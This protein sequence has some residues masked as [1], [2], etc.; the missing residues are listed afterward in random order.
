MDNKQLTK[1][2]SYFIM[3]DGG[4]YTR[5]GKTDSAYFVMNMKAE[6]KDYIDWVDSVLK[7]FVGTRQT[8]RKDYNTDGCNRQP[9]IRLE[10][11]THPKLATLRHRI[12]TEKYKGIDPHALKMLDWEALAILYM[13]DGSLCEDKPNPKKGLVNSSWNL[14][15]NMKRLSYGDQLLLKKAIKDKLDLEFNINRQNSYYYLRLRSKDVVKFCKGVEPYM[16]ESFKYK[17][18]V[19]DPLKEGGDTVCSAQQCAEVGRNDQSRENSHE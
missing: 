9:Q 1:L 8:D 14:T 2:L 13:C 16:K 11:K 15:L 5:N 10:S 7:T 6:N 12:Y 19:I 3:G 17:I 18:R 4:V